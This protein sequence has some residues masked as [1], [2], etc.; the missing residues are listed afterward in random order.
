MTGSHH[1]YKV[2]PLVSYLTMHVIRSESGL[3]VDTTRLSH[4]SSVRWPAM[5][6]LKGTNRAYKVSHFLMSLK[7]HTSQC[8]IFEFSRFCSSAGFIIL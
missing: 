3:S 6:S 4:S 2:K 5:H 8:S 1:K 7:D